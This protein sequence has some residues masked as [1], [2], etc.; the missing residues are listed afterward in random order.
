M[1][2]TVFNGFLTKPEP[3]SATKKLWTVYVFVFGRTCA[4]MPSYSLEM[5]P[6]MVKRWPGFSG[7]LSL[8]GFDLSI[9]TLHYFSAK[10]VLDSSKRS[11]S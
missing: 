3:R 9:H 5:T 4:N 11:T 2:K 8:I 7:A 1:T 10:S 6:I